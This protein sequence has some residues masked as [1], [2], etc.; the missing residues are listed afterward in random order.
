VVFSALQDGLSRRTWCSVVAPFIN[1]RLGRQ[2]FFSCSNIEQ[3]ILE[4]N[5]VTDQP[6]ETLPWRI[7]TPADPSRPA[8]IRLKVK[9]D[10]ANAVL[11]PRFSGPNDAITIHEN[12]NVRRRLLFF[13]QGTSGQWTPISEQYQLPLR[14]VDY[15][16]LDEVFDVELVI[17]LHGRFAQLWH[18]EN[19]ILY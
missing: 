14:C 17:T 11:Y 16:W 10:R 5:N 6:G 12:R 7:F 9:I 3:S 18:Y 13:A 8:T 19:M 4:L 1:P 2:Y 15:G